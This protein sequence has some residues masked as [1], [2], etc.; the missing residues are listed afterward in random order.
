MAAENVDEYT[1]ALS[2]QAPLEALL[3][4]QTELFSASGEEVAGALGD[5]ASRRTR[6]P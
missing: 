1:A 6:R 2:G 3:A 4:T 5:L